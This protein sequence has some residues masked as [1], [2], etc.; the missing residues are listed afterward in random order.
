MKETIGLNK[1]KLYSSVFALGFTGAAIFIIPYIKFVF[2]DL[3]IEVTGMTNT[4]SALLLTV[5]S[6]TSILAGIPCGQF[7]DKIDPKKGLLGALLVTTILTVFYAFAYR[8][9][10]LS[11]LIWIG[12]SI[13]T[14]GIY[15]PSFSKI[16]NVIGAKTD[17]SG[18]NKS[19]MSF[20]FYYMVNGIVAAILQAIALRASTLANNPDAAFR[21][22]ILITAAGTLLAMFVVQFMLDRGIVTDAQ[23]LQKE[24][25]ANKSSKEKKRLFDMNE[26]IEVHKNPL[27]PMIYIVCFVGYTMY[28]TQSYFTPFLTAVAG[29]TSETSGVFAIIRTYV[30]LALAPIGGMIADKV[31]G[32]TLKW[33]RISYIILAALV[34][35]MFLIPQGASPIL[36][37]IYTLIPAALVQ[38]TYTI[39]YSTIAEIKISPSVIAMV[40]GGAA[41][42]GSLADVVISPFIGYLLDTRGAQG[43]YIMFGML[44][45]ILI[46]GFI[47]T[48]V[49][50]KKVNSHQIR[51]A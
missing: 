34:F 14:M 19:G 16:L 1:R 15:W 22:V 11:L 46:I 13:T 24:Q 31:F 47:C 9:Y 44:V 6:I 36:I 50:L 12:L 42:V 41:A 20:G 25:N 33:F 39:K 29:V 38:M 8:S 17:K 40:T 7:V 21:L 35:G 51:E 4:Q 43:Y 27:V 28:T 3:Q 48:S 10:I 18:K 45:V 37:G 5:Y 26:I 49:I 30:F 23:Q 32:S 2:Y